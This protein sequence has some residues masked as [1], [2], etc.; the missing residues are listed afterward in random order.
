MTRE[1]IVVDASVAIALVHDE[2]DSGAIRETLAAW[3]AANVELVLP[4]HFWLEV[5]NPL[6]RRHGYDSRRLFEALRDLDEL[7]FTT[8]E[9]LRPQLVL[10]ISLMDR[11]GLTAYDAVYVALAQT[12]SARLASTDRVMLGAA[13]NLGLDPRLGPG[14]GLGHRLAEEPAP[15]GRSAGPAG[16]RP[17]TWPTWPGAGSY[18]AT[19]RRQAMSGR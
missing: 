15:Y 8:M 1:Q 18:L 6:A 12:I 4:G 17:V 5:V 13:G 2:P 10:A 7:P 19:L 3:I 11:H 9:T 14:P 16:G